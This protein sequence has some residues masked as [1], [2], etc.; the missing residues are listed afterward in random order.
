MKSL[1]ASAVTLVLAMTPGW[2]KD[3]VEHE[4]PSHFSPSPCSAINPC[5][6]VS[7]AIGPYTPLWTLQPAEK[8]RM[9]KRESSKT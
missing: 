7:P 9:Q 5:A 6:T 8:G 1:F 4:T 3:R 2:A